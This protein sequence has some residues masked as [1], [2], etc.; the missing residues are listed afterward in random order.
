MDYEIKIHPSSV[1]GKYYVDV[2]SCV[3]CCCCEETAPNNFKVRK[4]FEEN[5]G[6]FVFKQPENE[7]ELKQCKDAVF[8]CPTEA[9]RDNGE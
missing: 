9:V 1:K 6:A 2:N 8:C 7:Q 5:Y 4:G 3:T